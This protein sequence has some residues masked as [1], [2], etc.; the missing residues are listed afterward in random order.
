MRS[1][2][3]TVALVAAV[4]LVA[5]GCGADRERAVDEA[6]SYPVQQRVDECAEQPGTGRTGAGSAA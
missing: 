4:A 2:G 6:A 3:P 5:T 1:V